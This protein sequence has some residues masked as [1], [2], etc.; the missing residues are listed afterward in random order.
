MDYSL[1]TSLNINT[2]QESAA[3]L[4]DIMVA[5]R[6]H[7]EVLTKLNEMLVSG[8]DPKQVEK[9]MACF[10]KTLGVSLMPGDSGVTWCLQQAVPVQ[11]DTHELDKQTRKRLLEK[12]SQQ[13]EEKLNAKAVQMW[14]SL[15]RGTYWKR[16]SHAKT[17]I[18]ASRSSFGSLKSSITPS[19]NTSGSPIED[20]P[21]QSSASPI[22]AGPSNPGGTP[23]DSQLV[24]ANPDPGPGG[25]MVD[26]EDCNAQGGKNYGKTIYDK[27]QVVRFYYELPPEVHAKD[28]ACMVEFPSDLKCPGQAGRWVASAAKFKWESLPEDIQKSHRELPNTFRKVLGLPLKGQSR[29]K[30]IRLPQPLL[31]ALDRVYAEEA[32]TKSRDGPSRKKKLRKGFYCF[33]YTYTCIYYFLCFYDFVLGVSL[34][35]CKG[36]ISK[37]TCQISHKS[38]KILP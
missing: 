34:H 14:E 1:Y 30:S 2:K 13:R 21:G 25:Q 31:D 24:V 5:S 27:L 16:E 19:V 9:D 37:H 33:S 4:S 32:F 29:K 10:L 3:S 22:P 12:R 20:D 7:P 28:Q 26:A 15:E 35:F 6:K 38:A 23:A 11:E 8:L 17:T 36:R 18:K